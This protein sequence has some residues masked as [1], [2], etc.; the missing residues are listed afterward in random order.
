MASRISK[1]I[2]PKNIHANMVATLGD[3][4]FSLQLS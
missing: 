2:T 3:T 1:R 4:A